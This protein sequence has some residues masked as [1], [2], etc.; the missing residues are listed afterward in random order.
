M[1]HHFQPYMCNITSLNAEAVQNVLTTCAACNIM[2]MAVEC[3]GH[4]RYNHVHHV[5]QHIIGVALH[6]M[7]RMYPP[8]HYYVFVADPRNLRSDGLLVPMG[9]YPVPG[10]QPRMARFARN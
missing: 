9:H 3:T 8:S 1:P 2:C 6:G 4:V 10:S 7:R 5:G